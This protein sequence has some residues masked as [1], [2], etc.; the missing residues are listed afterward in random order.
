MSNRERASKIV[1]KHVQ[2]ATG[3]SDLE[4]AIATELNDVSEEAMNSAQLQ[5]A[6]LGVMEAIDRNGI[7]D[8]LRSSRAG[9]LALDRARTALRG[10][11]R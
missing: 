5:A 3:T 11:G 6:L 4:D 8:L 10:V 2:E 9:S 1:E 7:E